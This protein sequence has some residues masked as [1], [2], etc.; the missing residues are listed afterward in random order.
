MSDAAEQLRALRAE[1]LG[2]STSTGSQLCTQLVEA[3]D[4]WL[5]EQ[6][7]DEY[8]AALVAVGSYGRCDPAPHSDLDLVLLHR[9][10][11]D[12]A[13]VADRIWYPIW[14]AGVG[15]DH[16]VRTPAEAAKVA[17]DDLK[18][19]LGLLDA[20]LVAGDAG[21]AAELT[22]AV[23]GQWRADAKR[24]LPELAAATRARWES[25][26]EAA[27]LL[28]PDLKEARGGLRDLT[29]VRA[30]AAAWV[31]DAPS[32]TAVDAS[33]RLLDIRVALHRRSGRNL[34]RLL[35]QEQDGIAHDLGL[36]DADALAL[37][38]SKAA[39]VLAYAADT[40]LRR[41]DQFTAAPRRRLFAG[42]RESTR[43]PL[44]E[45]VV[46]QD[47]E[48]VLARTAVP[49]TDPGL[50][51]RL[52]AAA[53][54]ANLPIAPHALERLAQEAPALDSPWPAEAL[55]DLIALLGAGRSTVSVVE[56]LD[57]AGLWEPLLP[58]WGHVR[59][60]PQRNA[61]HRFTVD[62]HLLETAVE[63]SALTREVARPDLLLLGALLH[64]IGKGLPGDHSVVGESLVRELGPRLGLSAED[65]EVVA[66]LTRHHLLLPDTATR[67]D[68]D[69]P[70]TARAVAE[71]VGSRDALELLRALTI[72]DA[73]AT[74]PAAW[75]D[76][77]A[78]LVDA[79]VQRAAA[80]LSGA[81]APQPAQ[82]RADQ[83]ALAD[84]G[85]FAVLVVGHEVTVVAPD[86][87]G[88]LS[89]TAGVLALHRLDVR[90]ASATSVGEAAVTVLEAH[91]RF[92]S[93]PD[94]SVVRSDLSRAF[95][96]PEW[97]AHRLAARE[98]D[99]P[100]GRAAPVPP[101]VLL[102]DDASESATVLEVRAHDRLGLLH[103]VT[104]AIAASGLDVRAARISTLG[105]EAVDA[106]YVVDE[107]GEKLTDPARRDA[108]TSAVLAAASA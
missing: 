61:V 24:R 51:L 76:W 21:L 11:S 2:R 16:S 35:L 94:W 73:A 84:A 102:V 29:L 3:T 12:I 28:E 52:A 90:S 78:S 79:L 17:R 1:M 42:S 100:T 8:D 48:A 85:E 87:P 19:A 41:V 7:G 13:A 59:S 18:A 37:E 72:A 14:D 66:L 57:H 74:G 67:R 50:T 53:A 80:V 77:K 36:A 10:R 103:A 88:L 97:L 60:R 27:F 47:G 23:R 64:D 95:E 108:V 31:A 6:F 93:P 62:R 106:F 54:Q 5:K 107:Y 39:R 68:L 105:A 4:G 86:R 15:L 96:A 92:G 55:D 99:Y 89:R 44:A 83:Q 43:R 20:R 38:V 40:S 33:T 101:R 82:L 9:G 45:G 98:R 104:R 30:V 71:A 65:T 22:D 75:S 69:D 32:A 49:S 91:P 63:A 25:A 81:P 34:D 70:A 56:A 26:G 46:E 58:P